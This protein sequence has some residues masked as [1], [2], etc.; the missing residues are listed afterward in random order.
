MSDVN[1]KPQIIKTLYEIEEY[2]KKSGLTERDLLI[3]L[4]DR[5]RVKDR[6]SHKKTMTLKQIKAVLDALYSFEREL[7][8]NQEKALKEVESE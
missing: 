6:Y 3:L 1:L 8:R 7:I 4:R 5:I 2:I